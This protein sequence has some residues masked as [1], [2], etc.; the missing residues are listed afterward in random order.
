MKNMEVLNFF[1][2]KIINHIQPSADLNR[3]GKVRAIG[4]GV[5]TVF[6]PIVFSFSPQLH[7][8][9]EALRAFS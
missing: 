6:R 1:L 2:G 9:T 5:A 3:F 4:D 7:L 8:F